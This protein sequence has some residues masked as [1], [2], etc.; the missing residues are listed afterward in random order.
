MYTA[1]RKTI[2][3]LIPNTVGFLE[4]CAIMQNDLCPNFA[5]GFL[6]DVNSFQIHVIV[7]GPYTQS[8][9]ILQSEE[10]IADV[11]FFCFFPSNEH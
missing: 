8:V 1:G 11:F 5:F 10:Y 9:L 7:S 6:V 4:P 2:Y 3:C